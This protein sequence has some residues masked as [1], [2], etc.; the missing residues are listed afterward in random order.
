MSVREAAQ[1]SSSFQISTRASAM[2]T[3]SRTREACSEAEADGQLPIVQRVIGQ[4]GESLDEQT[5][6]QMKSRLGYNF[7][8]VRIHHDGGAAES[9]RAVRAQAYTVGQHVVFGGGKFSPHTVTGC[10]LLAHE[11]AHTVQQRD[12]MASAS[13]SGKAAETSASAAAQEITGGGALTQQLPRCRIGLARSPSD[14]NEDSGELTEAQKE[15]LGVV[16]NEIIE[17]HAKAPNA[18]QGGTEANAGHSSA[19]PDDERLRRLGELIATV[20][21]APPAVQAPEAPVD[22]QLDADLAAVSRNQLERR[23]EIKKDR[24]DRHVYLQ[25]QREWADVE[26]PIDDALRK[27]EVLHIPYELDIRFFQKELSISREEADAL[28]RYMN[29][30]HLPY[31]PHAT[32]KKLQTQKTITYHTDSL[33]LVQEMYEEMQQDRRLRLEEIDEILHTGPDMA[34][35]M[36]KDVGRGM[37]NGTL[38]FAQ[39]VIDTPASAVNLV[40]AFRGREP[41]HLLNLSGLR[42]DYQTNYGY[43]YGHSIELGTELGLAV[44]TG[45]VGGAGAGGGAAAE[46][47]SATS[48]ALR[49]LGILNKANTV[50]QGVT[51]AVRAEQAIEDLARGYT[52]VNGEKRPLTDDDI[53]DRIV[54]IGSTPSAIKGAVGSAKSLAGG[55]GNGEGAV[56]SST[57]TETSPEPTPSTSELPVPGGD[58]GGMLGGGSP[59]KSV[60]PYARTEEIPAPRPPVQRGNAA[61]GSARTLRPGELEAQTAPTAEQAAVDPHAPTQQLATPRPQVQRGNAAIA[62]ARTLHPS[63]LEAQTAA[64]APQAN[65]TAPVDAHAATEQVTSPPAAPDIGNAPTL[66]HDGAT[67][68]NAKTQPADAAVDPRGSTAE[69]TPAHSPNE[70]PGPVIGAPPPAPVQPGP[71]YDPVEASQTLANVTR[72][73]RPFRLINQPEIFAAEWRSQ[74]GPDGE[75]PAAWVDENGKITVDSSRVRAPVRSSDILAGPLR[76]PAPPAVPMGQTQESIPP[77]AAAPEAEQTYPD[78]DPYRNIGK[79]PPAVVTV[80]IDDPKVAKETYNRE[81]GASMRGESDRVPGFTNDPRIYEHDWRAAGGKGDKPP[82]AWRDQYGRL[83]VDAT[84]VDLHDL[85]EGSSSV[86]SKPG[87]DA[88]PAPPIEA[89]ENASAAHQSAPS[90]APALPMVPLNTFP[91]SWQKSPLPLSEGRDVYLYRGFARNAQTHMATVV[92]EG[93]IGGILSRDPAAAH[94]AIFN[95]VSR[96][97]VLSGPNSAGVVRI[98]IPAAIWDELVKTNSISERAGYPGFSREIDST[99]LRVNSLEAGR[100][101]NSLEKTVLPPDPYYDFRPGQS[102]PSHPIG[103]P[104]GDEPE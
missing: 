23:N 22:Q 50:T 87:G 96:E 74:H 25:A 49:L 51:T 81:Y 98:R 92:R 91:K 17:V 66:T 24:A 10:A 63:D 33:R 42:A 99:E 4:E 1:A 12:P 39:G 6:A 54:A 94:D 58:G 11:L 8:N 102:R 65:V 35:E 79:S 44:A 21:Q 2:N 88:P 3:R 29:W 16:D 43:H 77:A 53:I 56:P 85:A 68:G 40:Q 67:L 28:M 57:T 15:E 41:V 14:Q 55:G 71:I 62:S 20:P 95:Q 27:V 84:A 89:G 72:E 30:T 73:G 75:L 80:T 9:A 19:Q 52:I 59:P 13:P 46:S 82:P 31:D 78:D 64:T 93:E 104:E 32:Q 5:Q 36:F 38:E 7:G 101:I 47:A 90:S 83:F 60:D 69:V 86:S 103:A 45:K 37:Y 70:P 61:I 100:L 76:Q 48:K 34:L 26:I 97:P 18:S